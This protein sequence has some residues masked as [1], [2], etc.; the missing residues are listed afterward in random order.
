L[1]TLFAGQRSADGKPLSPIRRAVAIAVCLGIVAVGWQSLGLL[2]DRVAVTGTVH[3][4]GK[5]LA[6]GIIRFIPL[7]SG[8]EPGGAVIVEGRYLIPGSNGLAPGLYA[9]RITAPRLSSAGNDGTAES[10]RTTELIP[11]DYN[12][13][14]S[15]F[16]S[17]QR[18][19][20]NVLDFDLSPK[21][22]A[23]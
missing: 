5:P 14:T 18:G 16:R 2:H 17:V 1:V 23:N 21:F 11:F 7:E 12:Q 4:R 8:L 3:F 6:K 19:R 10:A 22:S 15:L 13:R 20:S 9:I